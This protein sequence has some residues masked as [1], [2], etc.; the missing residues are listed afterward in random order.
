MALRRA[1]GENGPQAASYRNYLRSQGFDADA[2]AQPVLVARRITSLSDPERVAWTTGANRS[3][4]LRMSA[5]ETALADARLL[6]R[7]VLRLWRGGDV[8]VAANREFVRAFHSRLSRGEQGAMNDAAGALSQEGVRRLQAA[9]FARAYGDSVVLGRV[10]ESVDNNIRAIGGAMADAA[11]DI[12]ALRAA[13][14]AGEVPAGMDIS[15]DLLEAVALVMRARDAGRPLI[16]LISQGDLLFDASPISTT[17]LRAMFRDGDLRTPLGRERI[18][19]MLRDYAREAAKVTDGPMLLGEPLEARDVLSAAARK[20]GR[21]DLAAGLEA[22]LEPEAI[23]A[24]NEKP[25]AND[26]IVQEAF[27]LAES[28]PDLTVEVK[29]GDTASQVKIA[30]LLL[31]LDDEIAAAKQLQ[32]CAVGSDIGVAA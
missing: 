20:A 12:A 8:S 21:E 4:V 22:R 5:A 17:L 1:Y 23:R 25:E 32:G 11:G 2:L 24:G 14:A 3:T 9:L 26:A 15:A 16:E 19:A 18:A 29:V 7:D 6:S 27:R 10:L 28:R 30:D 13:V 31:E